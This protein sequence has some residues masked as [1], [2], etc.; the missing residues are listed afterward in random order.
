MNKA[1]EVFGKCK[2]QDENP[3]K[4]KAVEKATEAVARKKEA[5]ESRITHVFQS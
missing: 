4:K 1:T 2:G 3:P 5:I